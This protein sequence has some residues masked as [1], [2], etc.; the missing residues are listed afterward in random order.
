M[1]VGRIWV[2]AVVCLVFQMGLQTTLAKEDAAPAK[3][4]SLQVTQSTYEFEKVVE[5]QDVIHDFLIKNTGEGRL[6]ILNVKPG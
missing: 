3:A 1:K 5:G 6:D 4:P 2:V